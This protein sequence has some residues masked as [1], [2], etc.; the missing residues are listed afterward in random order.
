MAVYLPI[1][2]ASLI[3]GSGLSG[4]GTAALAIGVVAVIL[5]IA[6]RIEEPLSSMIFNRSDEALLLTILGVAVLAA[7]LAEG[8]QISAAVGALLA[9]IVISGPAAESARGLLAPLRDLF[10][11]IF[12]AFVGLSVDP[13]SIP[14]TIGVAVLLALATIVTQF[15]AGWLS[16]SWAGIGPNGRTRAGALL[17]AR[18]EFSL[19]I[20]ELAIA[21]GLVADL[22]PLTVSYVMIMAIVGPVASRVVELPAVERL[23]ARVGKPARRAS[24][25]SAS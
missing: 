18:G 7:G 8:L 5:A 20:A 2:S 6:V 13:G 3:G 23:S 22:A 25:R 24:P 9:G 10:A 16:A 11:A 1:L 15:V 21:G 4:I 12:F 17:L 14:P 19:A